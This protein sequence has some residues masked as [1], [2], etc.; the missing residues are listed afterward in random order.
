MVSVLPQNK[1]KYTN[2]CNGTNADP[3]N[4]V[5]IN[6]NIKGGDH[7][8]WSWSWSRNWIT[9]EIP[10]ASQCLFFW[11][12]KNLWYH[13]CNTLWVIRTLKK[14]WF[15]DEIMVVDP[16]LKTWT[17]SWWRVCDNFGTYPFVVGMMM[18]TLL[19]WWHVLGFVR[20]FQRGHGLGGVWG[21][22][23]WDCRGRTN[24][25]QKPLRE[26]TR[27][28]ALPSLRSDQEI[29][30]FCY[31][32]DACPETSYWMFSWSS[33]TS[34]WHLRETKERKWWGQFN[35]REQNYHTP[36]L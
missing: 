33:P 28:K 19:W 29:S 4:Q 22:K 20:D 32:Y 21:L 36:K 3:Q 31:D 25:K 2:L 5:N 30:P 8:P 13:G 11:K 27:Q 17:W 7:N 1:E 10:I 15:W 6:I 24:R 34:F 18:M 26:W 23:G 16:F 14:T 12:I 9:I 35:V